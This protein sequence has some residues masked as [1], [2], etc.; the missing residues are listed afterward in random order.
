[1]G[2]MECLETVKLTVVVT[3][4]C[5]TLCLDTSARIIT[6]LNWETTCSRLKLKINFAREKVIV[7]IPHFNFNSLH[8]FCLFPAKVR[9]GIF[10]WF[11]SI[12]AGNVPV[13]LTL[14]NA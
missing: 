9:L 11:V 12:F 8:F 14:G 6:S 4:G 2:W 7:V 1:M 10:Y 5:L 3:E 13:Y